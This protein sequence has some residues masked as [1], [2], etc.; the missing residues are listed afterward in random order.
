MAQG[1]AFELETQLTICS[2]LNLIPHEKLTPVLDL[3]NKEQQ[4]LNSL[5]TIIKNGTNSERLKAKS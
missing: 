4:M 5:I 3:L 2:E 1:S